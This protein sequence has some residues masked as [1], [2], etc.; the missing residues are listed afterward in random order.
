MSNSMGTCGHELPY[1]WEHSGAAQV[2]MKDYDRTGNRTIAYRIVCRDCRC[3]YADAG[4]LLTTERQRQ[5]WLR[6]KFQLKEKDEQH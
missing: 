5:T 2:A 4:E 3:R 1:K 6:G